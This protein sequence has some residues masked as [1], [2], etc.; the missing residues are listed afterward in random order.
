[1]VSHAWAQVKPKSAVKSRL[2]NQFLLRVYVRAGGMLPDRC[3]D[4]P[5]C[6]RLTWLQVCRTFSQQFAITIIM[7][8]VIIASQL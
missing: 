8:I 4:S 1:M 7:I 6:S 2:I 3:L 5:V